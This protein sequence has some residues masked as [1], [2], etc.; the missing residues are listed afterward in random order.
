[1]HKK[2]ISLGLL[3]ATSALASPYEVNCKLYDM[4][5]DV[6]DPPVI[7][8]LNLKIKDTSVQDKAEMKNIKFQDK[9]INVAVESMPKEL[10]EIL[11][12]VGFTMQL[13]DETTKKLLGASAV[14]LDKSNKVTALFLS[15]AD[16][17]T[18]LLLQCNK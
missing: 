4:G 17:A 9:T 12:E 15:T 2:L 6:A 13:F 18:A 1:M 8:T 10:S 7:Q 14:G 5:G 11:G 16:S 3:L